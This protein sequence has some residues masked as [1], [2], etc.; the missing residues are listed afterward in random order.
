MAR[1][2]DISGAGDSS[3]AL[4]PFVHP[5]ETS[6]RYG[7][8]M[9]RGVSGESA[10]LTEHPSRRPVLLAAALGLSFSAA[11]VAATGLGATRA[12][13]DTAAELQARAAA[14]EQWHGR[15]GLGAAAFDPNLARL[16]TEVAIAHREAKAAIAV[17]D[18]AEGK[19]TAEQVA[20]LRAAAA[21]LIAEAE[22]AVPG[23]RFAGRLIG[24]RSL[25]DGVTASVDAWQAAE[26]ERAA[27]LAAEAAAAEA[28]SSDASAASGGPG[29]LPADVQAAFDAMARELANRPPVFITPTPPPQPTYLCRFEDGTVYSSTSLCANPA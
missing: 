10:A 17:A 7:A 29:R 12:A 25:S 24:V 18:G 21:H 28:E 15:V 9:S 27:R 22:A 13:A 19:A 5:P 1:T 3:G 8:A 26:D 16:A 4:P 23:H 6:R 2:A 20:A 14:V 11:L